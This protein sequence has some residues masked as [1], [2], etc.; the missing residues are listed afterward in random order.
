MKAVNTIAAQGDVLFERIDALPSDAKALP[1]ADEYIVAH[2]E[3]GHHHVARG[4]GA[5]HYDSPDPFTHYIVSKG[6]ITVT[7]KRDYDT[8]ETLSLLSRIDNTL[9]ANAVWRVRQ[10]R[11]AT[12]SG[13]ERVVD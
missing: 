3:T 9:D 6:D 7:H 2:S 13:M 4:R 10:Q 5:R 11:Q 1:Q 12:P 8:H